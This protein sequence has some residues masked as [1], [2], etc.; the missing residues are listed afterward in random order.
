MVKNQE[1][2]AATVANL[3]N[4]PG[5]QCNPIGLWDEWVNNFDI[6]N[7]VYTYVRFILLL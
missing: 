6:K 3:E 4:I 2:S 1:L 7:M 5:N